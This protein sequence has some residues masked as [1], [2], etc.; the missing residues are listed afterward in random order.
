MRRF[1]LAL[2]LVLLACTDSQGAGPAGRFR[3]T[4][5]VLPGSQANLVCFNVRERFRRAVDR[6]QPGAADTA[7]L[8]AA[9]PAALAAQKPTGAP[10]WSRRRE[11]WRANMSVCPRR[12][13]VSLGISIRARP[14][15][16][17]G[18]RPVAAGTGHGLRRRPGLLRRRIWTSGVH[19]THFGFNGM[20]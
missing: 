20:A 7:A 5:V 16:I 11:G 14:T 3:S 8:E 15:S 17:A 1:Q 13:P 4:P 6:P 19:F 18:S 10:D 2:C 12:P 9:L